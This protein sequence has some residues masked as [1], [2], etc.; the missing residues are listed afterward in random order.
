MEDCED[1]LIFVFEGVCCLC[2]LGDVCCVLVGSWGWCDV[3]NIWG[4]VCVDGTSEELVN[5]AGVL[6]QQGSEL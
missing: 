5:A 2:G 3:V 6:C 4:G 1:W